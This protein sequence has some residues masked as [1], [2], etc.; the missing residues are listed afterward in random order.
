MLGFGKP[1]KE[2][3]EK[4]CSQMSLTY[5]GENWHGYPKRWEPVE[6]SRWGNYP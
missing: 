5:T 1:C 3:E 2:E 4:S 6:A